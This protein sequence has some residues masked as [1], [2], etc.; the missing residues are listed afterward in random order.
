MEHLIATFL[1]NAQKYV[2]EQQQQTL[3]QL[4]I[5]QQRIEILLA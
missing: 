1:K 3:Q 5:K 4:I 2:I